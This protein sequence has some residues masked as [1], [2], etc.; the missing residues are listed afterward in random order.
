M[1]IRRKSISHLIL[2][3]IL[4]T[5]FVSPARAD[6]IPELFTFHGAGYGH[7]VGMSQIGARGMALEGS[8]AIDILQYFYKDVTVEDVRDDQDLRVNIGHL[9][10]IFSLSTDAAKG[11]MELYLG[12]VKDSRTV[13]PIKVIPSKAVL[14]FT[15][16]G[17]TA[18]PSITSTAGNVDA[19][20]SGK[21]WTLRWTGTRFLAGANSYVN[22]KKNG[23]TT[24]YRYG[25]IQ[26][27]LVKVAVLG[28]RIEVTNSVRLHDEYLW[29]L[30]E[31]PS[32]WP[33]AAMQAQVIASRTYALNKAGKIRTGCD[34]DLYN[35]SQD[36][37]FIGY[38]KELEPKFGKIWRSAVSST[39]V[40]KNTGLAV[41]YQ[42]V[43]IATYFFSSSAGQTETAKNVWGTDL[44]YI[45]SVPDPWSLDPL[46]NP[47]YFDWVRTVSQKVLASAFG[48]M[49]VVYL[50][51]T[52]LH[53]NAQVLKVAGTSSDGRV[54]TITGEQFRS[55]TGLPSPWFE[56]VG[57]TIIDASPSPSPTQSL[58]E[59]PTPVATDSAT[60]TPPSV[61]MQD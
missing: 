49:D 5:L 45:G 24:R 3:F 25:Q 58:T 40:D 47:R 57:P 54:V 28:Y 56:I 37:S 30:G 38:A 60:P 22:F 32:S 7:G 16:L 42:S 39:S 19:L 29:G 48:L 10:S 52:G 17:N 26:I 23:A 50:N 36:Q 8:N 6:G 31:M 51:V 12:D 4:S 14:N 41:L 2:I 21:S 18:I 20:S 61:G 33:F 34:C 35:A 43:P 44:P 1:R 46:I 55:R 13:V 53:D 59:S 9:L 27:K 15:L 11:R